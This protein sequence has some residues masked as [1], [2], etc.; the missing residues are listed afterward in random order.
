MLNIIIGSLALSIIHAMIPNHWLPFVVI[1]KSERWSIT[2]TIGGTAIA[3]FFHIISSI[4]VG[5]LIG[6]AG[7]TLFLSYEPIIRIIAPAVL[8]AIGVIFLYLD[9]KKG[10]NHHH[11]LEELGEKK[12][13]ASYRSIVF[14]LS[15]AMFFSPCVDLEAYYF[16]AGTFGWN[17]II[18]VS[19]IY[20]IVT[21]NAMMAMVYFGW[22]GL[23]K[24]NLHF[25]E[26]HEKLVS[27]IVL[28]ILAVITYFVY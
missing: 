2:Q 19:V 7:Y 27:G 3:G 5:I 25:L 16:T 15:V 4:M 11:H 12:N 6:W 17:A 28:M 14:S 23:H 9:L 21:V 24:L 13:N 22:K 1:G 20:L 10:Q 18:I 26:H 8:M